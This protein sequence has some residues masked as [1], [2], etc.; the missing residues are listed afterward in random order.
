MNAATIPHTRHELARRASGGIEVALFWSA[1]D[2]STTV[3]VL[4]AATGETLRFTVARTG[5]LDAFYHPFAHLPS[6]SAGLVPARD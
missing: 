5:A 2:N 3:E 6:T 4:Q 1:T